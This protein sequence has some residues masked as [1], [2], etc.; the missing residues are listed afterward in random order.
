MKRSFLLFLVLSGTVIGCQKSEMTNTDTYF[1]ASKD[2][3]K[4]QATT[5][6]AHLSSGSNIFTVYGTR[7]DKKYYQEEQIRFTFTTGSINESGTV[8]NFESEFLDIVG[9]DG[10]SNSFASR[11]A[12]PGNAVTITRIDT[13]NHE[14]EGNF[15][16][17]LKRNPHW[18][19]Q[20]EYLE[21]RNGK[22][23]VKYTQAP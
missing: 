10:I 21:I 9:G 23:K 4:W 1:T 19:Q 16:L 8:T 22:F 11:A 7:R 13:V 2:K 15:E 18:T 3:D 17:R 6:A 12:D 5:V 20:T 14:L